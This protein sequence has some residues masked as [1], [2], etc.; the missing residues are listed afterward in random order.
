MKCIYP[1]T[2]DPITNGHMDVIKRAKKV[3]DEIIV[4][5]AKND[6]KTPY[7]SLEERIEFAKI[8]TAGISGISV[9]GFN[10]LLVDFAKSQGT[11]IVVRGLRAVSDF[12]YEFQMGY[13][14]ATLMNDFETIYFMP[15]LQ[16]AFI[17]S[18]IVRSIL[19]H[20]GDVSKLVPSVILEHLKDKK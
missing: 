1:G 8:A 4:A 9:M 17:S 20:N 13:A 11:N 19:A 6:N 18:S 3:F 5:V 10:S 12:E 7:F 15:Q 16:N 2:F 14:N